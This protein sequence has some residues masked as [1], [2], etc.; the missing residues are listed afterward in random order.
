MIFAAQSFAGIRTTGNG[1]GNVANAGDVLSVLGQQR[2]R[3]VGPGQH[4]L[5]TCCC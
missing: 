2:V 1:L 4:V 5:A 3:H